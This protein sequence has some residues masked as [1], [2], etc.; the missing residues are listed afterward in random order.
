LGSTPKSRPSLPNPKLKPIVL[1]T[2]RKSEKPIPS[3]P[4]SLQ[5]HHRAYKNETG[6]Q[7]PFKSAKGK[8]RALDNQCKDPEAELSSPN[9]TSKRKGRL[10]NLTDIVV[11]PESSTPSIQ[12]FPSKRVIQNAD[13]HPHR[14]PSNED[15]D[16]PILISSPS[17]R[18]SHPG[19]VE[20][21]EVSL[22]SG[23]SSSLQETRKSCL[24]PSSRS[25]AHELKLT[26]PVESRKFIA[27]PGLRKRKRRTSDLTT[28]LPSGQSPEKRMDRKD[29]PS[30]QASSHASSSRFIDGKLTS[31]PKAIY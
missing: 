28:D 2:P 17:H 4:H 19:P 5:P 6:E 31:S 13:P 22:F 3:A 1:L 29:S 14:A 21:E 30:R 8:E 18:S 23:T 26:P 15:S 25:F 10:R 20:N 7:R 16:D 9:K 11:D 12:T 27:S 24:L